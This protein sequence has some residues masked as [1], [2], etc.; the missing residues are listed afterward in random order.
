M[1]WNF[2]KNAVF[3]CKKPKL[4]KITNGGTSVHLDARQLFNKIKFL[5]NI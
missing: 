5:S 3:C 2:L 4:S 1:V